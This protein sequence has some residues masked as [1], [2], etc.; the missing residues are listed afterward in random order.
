MT[1]GTKT[2]NLVLNLQPNRKALLRTLILWLVFLPLGAVIIIPVIYM[3]SMA[4][5]TEQN[6]LHFPIE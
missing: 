2:S 5:T 3:V 6:Q 4:F 1:T